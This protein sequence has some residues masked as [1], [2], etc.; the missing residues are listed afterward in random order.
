MLKRNTQQRRRAIVER[1]R[2]NGDVA[3]DELAQLFSTSEVTIRKDLTELESNGLL[4]RRFGGAVRVPAENEAVCDNEVSKRKFDIAIAAAQLIK[5]HQRIIIDSGSTTAALMPLLASKRGLVVMTNSLHVAHTLLELE[6]E[7]QVLMTG[8][9]WDSLSHSFQ[10]QMAESM[11]QAY[12]FDIA[13]LGA[14]G[15]DL[16]RGTTTFNELTS[17]SRVMAEVSSQV[18]VMAESEKLTRKIPNVELPWS[19]I[20]TL[21]TDSE[22]NNEAITQIEA[23]GVDVICAAA[24]N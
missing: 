15:L 19:S 14:A 8:G 6:N 1:L 2:V 7:P 10:G 12:N 18:V 23:Y 11:L 22:I 5:D 16:K 9:T 4:L 13:F 21:V 3:V 20:T 24:N 17:L